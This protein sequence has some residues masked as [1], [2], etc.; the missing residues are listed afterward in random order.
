MMKVEVIYTEVDS[1]SCEYG[2]WTTGH[3]FKI[4]I[5][6]QV[7]A[8]KEAYATCTSCSSVSGSEVIQA[9]VE[10]LGFKNTSV[11]VGRLYIGDD[12]EVYEED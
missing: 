9:L 5:D 10:A 8:E 1:G 12:S 2:C 3:G 6:E 11:E 7:V 4:L